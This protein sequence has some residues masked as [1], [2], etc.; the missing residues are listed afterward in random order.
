MVSKMDTWSAINA[1]FQG[2]HLQ[3]LVQHQ[4]ES[5]NEFVMTQIQQT[6]EQFN[7]VVIHSDQYFNKDF[8]KY[9]LEIMIR[10][11]NFQ[12]NRPQIHENNGSTK[13]MFPQEARLRNFTYAATT[14]ID[15]NIQYFVRT[16]PELEDVQCFNNVIK[17]IHIGK[18]PI[19]LKSSA[20][21]LTQYSHLSHSITGECRYDPGGYFIINGSEK[22]VLGQERMAENKIYCFPASNSHKYLFQ[23]EIKCSPDSKRISP[24]QVNLYLMKVANGEFAIHV[25]LPRIRK[26]IPIGIVFRALG[27][28]SD[29]QLCQFMTLNSPDSEM[30]ELLRGTI[31]E[32]STCLTEEDAIL[33]IAGHVMF[34]PMYTDKPLLKKR[35]FALEVIR[36][37]LFS[38]CKTKDQQIH[39]L[40]YM[41]NK[42]LMCAMK[43]QPCDDR[44]SYLNK[45]VGLTGTLLNDLYRNYFN[46]M[47]KDMQKQIIREMNT[48][49]WK[50]KE[51]YVQI[52]T[53]TNVYKIVK[54]TM[55]ENGLKRALSTGD[56]GT[57]QMN[58]NKVG[59]AQVL[60]RL[61]YASSLSH[62]RRI[63]TPSGQSGKLVAPRKLANSTWGFL[64]P[65]ETP[66]GQS[67]GIVKNMSYMTHITI[68]SDSSSLYKHV[69]PFLIPLSL[70]SSTKVFVNGTW[71]GN[72][73]QPQ[74]L[75][76]D[77]KT[78]KSSSVI[79]I[80]T[81]IVFDYRLNEIQICNDA[82]R[83]VRPVFKVRHNQLLYNEEITLLLKEKKL[84]WD[85]LIISKTNE[86]VIE[87]IDPCEQN[88][89]MISMTPQFDKKYRYTHCELNPSTIFGVLASCI[90]FPEHNQSPRNTYQCA[91]GKQAIGVYV[92][93]YHTRMDKTAWVL[94]YPHRP[95]VDTRIMHMLKLNELPSG[96]PVIVAIMSHTGYNQEDSIMI[97]QGAIDRGLFRTTAFETKRDDNKKTH[98]EDEIRCKPDEQ[99]TKGMK[100]S[101][102]SK[103]G[104]DGL[105][106]KNTLIE[107]MDIVMG[108]VSPLKDARNDP[109]K[110]IKFED[111]SKYHR[112]DEVC[113]LDENYIGVNG[114]GYTTW[115]CRIR[116][117]RTPE[118]GDKFSSRHGQKGTV[119]NIIEEVDLPFTESGLKPDIIIN[120]HAI[121][122]RMTIGQLKETLL[123]KVL[124]ELGIFGD[125]TAFTDLA[126]STIS[127]ELL[128]VGY[129]SN[130]NEIM[131]NGLSG[132]QMEMSIFIGP[133]FYQR[134]KHMVV[135]K[136]HSRSK[137]PMVNLTRQ[138]AEGRSRDG[139]LRFGEMERDCMVSHG[140]AAFTK[141]RMYDASDAFVVY[142]CKKCGVIAS[143][144]NESH[145]HLCRLC[146]N[147]T[148][149]N[150]VYMPYAC[151][152]LFHELIT[153]NV[154]PRMITK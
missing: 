12:I 80:Y 106:P 112:T 17:Q 73:L 58:S 138:P 57:K 70:D 22:T 120:P 61:T 89:A 116:A 86:A 99:R 19:M 38:H 114:D 111:E 152:L 97:S 52:I 136:H 82:G 126:V 44:D 15:I 139:G 27:I 49:S 75:Y 151:K 8:K 105:M 25:N 45:R 36:N 130:G 104:P 64:C 72:S 117:D 125:G 81:S 59:V 35:E 71:V 28:I 39:L 7:P 37:D 121:P 88:A 100:F 131:Y 145:I 43:R 85:D 140:A 132:E 74:E 128:K 83:L 60:N 30:N 91:M 118:I 127:K 115:K 46:K 33:Y 148:D 84:F 63:N 78:K 87:Y 143:H 65:A 11:T 48:G 129:E 5:Y 113:Y 40:G 94:N 41:A 146:E 42:L 51:D 147:R 95:L 124:L 76:N 77:M 109:T 10:F 54:S 153:M 23:A 2:A 62:L 144:N 24:K 14:T 68:R 21:V 47:V 55:I 90:P 96:T 79:N 6:I 18:L 141:G 9:S 102:Y 107:N 119:G 32:A 16:G 92:T 20:C 134:L 150:K 69:E 135:D 110:K 149:F 98:G 142:V 103:I 26:F 66:E 133:V 137:G 53:P 123:G 4:I 31:M 50:S 108:K 93:N 101:N 13:V 154:V 1:Y 67:V 3:R 122:S 34:T 56:F 29:L